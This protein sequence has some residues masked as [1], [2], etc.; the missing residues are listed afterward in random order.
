MDNRE[1]PEIPPEAG[2]RPADERP[3]HPDAGK[4]I[5][6]ASDDHPGEKHDPDNTKSDGADG[7][8]K[9]IHSGS[10]L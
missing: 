7:H 8:A 6:T 3:I 5:G 9:I 4:G 2:H 1:T 10:P